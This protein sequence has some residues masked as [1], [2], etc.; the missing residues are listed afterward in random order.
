MSEAAKH[1]KEKVENFLLKYCVVGSF[2][3]AVL[4]GVI[5]SIPDIHFFKGLDLILEDI[6]GSILISVLFIHPFVI[7]LLNV[8][9]LICCG[10]GEQWKRKGL[11]MEILTLI[12]GSIYTLLLL[13]FYVS[14]REWSGRHDYSW[15]SYDTVKQM[16]LIMMAVLAVIGVL[17]YLIMRTSKNIRESKEV[18]RGACVALCLGMGACVMWMLCFL[19]EE[20]F[21]IY[22][23]LLPFNMILIWTKVLKESKNNQ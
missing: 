23:C 3:I 8:I 20:V 22:F 18:F 13:I 15:Q 21:V 14:L 4:V 6:L 16:Y 5:L 12:E 17:G 11:H 19:Q 10:R 9:F 2:W 7:T 1:K